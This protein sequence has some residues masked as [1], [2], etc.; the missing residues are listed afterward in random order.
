MGAFGKIC[1][2]LCLA[3]P[4]LLISDQFLPKYSEQDMASL[5]F[6]LLNCFN[7]IRYNISNEYN[8]SILPVVEQLSEGLKNRYIQKV[9]LTNI[10]R[11]MDAMNTTEFQEIYKRRNNNQLV[12][13]LSKSIVLKLKD[14]A[15][16]A[17]TPNESLISAMLAKVRSYIDYVL[18]HDET[19]YDG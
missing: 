17:M 19:S 10:L 14:S 5:E 12:Q 16:L 13:F 6:N 3:V 18:Q 2:Y 8:T 11:C 4:C 9:Y 15:S 1:V 7:M